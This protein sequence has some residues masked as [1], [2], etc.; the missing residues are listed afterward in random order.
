MV[1][2]EVILGLDW[3]YIGRILGRTME[4]QHRNDNLGLRVFWDLGFRG[5]FR[6]IRQVLNPTPETSISPSQP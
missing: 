2:M 6:N 1:P 3:G 4:K 5:C